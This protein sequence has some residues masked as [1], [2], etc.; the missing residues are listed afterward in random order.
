MKK[1]AF[2]GGGSAG[3]VVP[4]IALMDDLLK[5]GGF[6]TCYFGSNGM[7]KELICARNIPYFQTECPKLIRSKS[8]SALRKNIKIPFLLH[9]A[10]SQVKKTLK[11][12]KP[13]LVFSKGGFVSLPVVLAARRL[14]I[15]CFTHESDYSAGLANRLIAKKCNAVFT[16]FPETATTFK[17]GIFTG[18]PMR[19]EL[20]EKDKLSAK[21]R[22]GFPIS[23]PTILVVGGGQGSEFLNKSVRN[24]LPKLKDFSVLH[25]CGKGNVEKSTLENYRQFEYLE[26]IGEAYAAA[27]V[28]VSRAGA[29]AIF[30]ILALKKPALF[31][32]LENASRGDQIENA[33]YFEDKGLCAVLRESQIQDLPQAIREVYTNET[34]KR[35]LKK[36]NFDCG[37]DR[38]LSHL[39]TF[40]Q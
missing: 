35:A 12:E 23:K 37:N 8:L 18:A 33:K 34:L 16:S 25:L 36:C 38:I 3:H 30:E 10:V 22:F 32:P 39:K 21:I 7:E 9:R 11:K 29:G 28:V 19:K 27:D 26:D 31:V 17:N 20:F 6:E 14:K 24:A 2:T 15:P 4:N 1:I 5:T 13:D 40:L